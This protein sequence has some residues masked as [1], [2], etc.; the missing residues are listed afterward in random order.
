MNESSATVLVV[1]DDPAY[2]SLVAT[3]LSE[4]GYAVREAES[5]QAA[6]E[7]GREEAPGLVLL[8]VRLP[9]VSGY[10]LCSELRDEF[11]ETLP[12]IFVSGAKTDQLDR[13]GGLLLGADDYIVKP[14][15]PGDL[16][17]RVRR[18]ALRM[19]MKPQ[20]RTRSRLAK[21]LTKREREV[22]Y[23]LAAG[24]SQK[25]IA[26]ALFITQ[27]TVATHLQHILAKL[28]VHSRAEAVALA[29]RE[30]LARLP[31]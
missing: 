16:L 24:N 9:D 26:T 11:G 3:L 10:E 13:V 20:K 21:K 25:Q 1:D 27:K 18:S 15:D 17:A 23:L 28:G 8:D 6:R 30:G 7:A 4:A 5:G 2:R 31:T 22:L 19:G 12:I 14:F 29:H